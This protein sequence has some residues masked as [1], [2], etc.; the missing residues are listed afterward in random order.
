[1]KVAV[2]VPATSNRRDWTEFKQTD[3]YNNLF[4]SFFT[5]YNKN[6]NYT[7]YIGVDED[8]KL[9]NNA[10]VIEQIKKFFS[11]MINTEINIITFGSEYKGKP[12][13][14]WNRLY[15]IS[16]K[17]NDFFLQVGSDIE[18]VDANWCECMIEKLKENNE[19]GV[20]GLTDAGRRQY[21]SSDTLLT[22]TMVS[23]R[24][25]EIF[26]F[27]FPPE[28]TSWFSDNWIG[29]IYER[30]GKKFMIH[31]R[32]INCGGEPRYDVPDDC[33]YQY[34]VC[35]NKYLKKISKYQNEINFFRLR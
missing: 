13:H 10:D 15:E 18:F 8:D 19:I 7:F 34:Q 28:L 27:Y 21:D 30:Y 2:L 12:C 26:S 35:L 33:R 24:H 32:I 22:Q 29:D 6:H 11:V 23:K 14:I 16:L 17:E 9:Y 3:L 1:M 25:Y 20:V 4:K 5:T 31:Q